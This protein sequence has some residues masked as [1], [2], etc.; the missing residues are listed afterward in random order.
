MDTQ[1][2]SKKYTCTECDYNT[3]YKQT[4]IKHKMTSKH[5][6]S[7]IG[8]QF[9]TNKIQKNNKK[10]S[11]DACDFNTGNKT[12]YDT[13]LTT[14]KHQRNISV[15]EPQSISRKKC[16]DCQ[17]CGKEFANKSGLWKHKK[18][19]VFIESKPQ[20]SGGIPQNLL[21]ELIKSNIQTAFFEESKK[22]HNII[23]E[24]NDKI[25][26]LAKTQNVT[27]NN[28][29][30]N[31]TTTNNNN[32]F[33][34]NLFLNETCKDAI[35]ITDFVNSVKLQISDFEETGRIGYVEGITKIFLKCLKEYDVEKRPMHCTDTKRETVYIKNNDIWEKE[36]DDKKYLNWAV[37]AVANLNFN[38][39]VEWQKEHPD[40]TVNDS[41]SNN[42]FM[43]LTSVALG[44][45]MNQNED[46]LREKIMKNVLKEITI[47]KIKKGVK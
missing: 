21:I 1:K 37:G 8:Y 41:K 13:H 36:N 24:Q 3:C 18:K 47:D 26:E 16:H 34:L 45:H 35:S 2:S 7:I 20:E 39:H 42:E 30:N 6:I 15:E 43:K 11:C 22:M 17:I 25:I 4:I 29:T 27:N 14:K 32:Q 5:E 46:K 38:Q 31:N 28:I 40:C 10:Y 19:C 33:N 12:R 44:G 9:D 23:R